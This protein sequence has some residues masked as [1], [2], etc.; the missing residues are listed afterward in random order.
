MKVK[1]E[2]FS[3]FIVLSLI[4]LILQIT[5]LAE[6]GWLW[7]FAPIWIPF[8]FMGLFI[9]IGLLINRKIRKD[10]FRNK[11]ERKK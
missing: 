2:G 5:G 1:I 11:I 9:I 7:V 4:L 10:I 3:F 6:I 8:V